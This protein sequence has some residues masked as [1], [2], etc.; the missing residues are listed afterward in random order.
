MCWQCHLRRMTEIRRSGFW[1][2]ATWR[3][4][5]TCLG[6]SMVSVPAP[7]KWHVSET[8][9]ACTSQHYSVVHFCPDSLC[10]R[11]SN[12]LSQ[13]KS[14]RTSCFWLHS[15]QLSLLSCNKLSESQCSL[16]LTSLI[17][18]IASNIP[19]FPQTIDH[20]HS[21]WFDM[22]FQGN[23]ACFKSPGAGKCSTS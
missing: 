14:L 8:S 21:S 2:T 1:T 5:S 17:K 23:S 6:K 3:R 10:R 12:I 19:P 18:F 22:P 15:K 7:S 20:A 13:P 11:T 9:G 4:C 16:G